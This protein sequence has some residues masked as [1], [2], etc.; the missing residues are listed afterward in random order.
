M[1]NSSGFK[2]VEPCLQ[3]QKENIG[4]G[5]RDMPKGRRLVPERSEETKFWLGSGAA[6]G[7]ADIKKNDF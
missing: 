3:F 1:N 2:E 5:S 7:F 6:Q 4:G